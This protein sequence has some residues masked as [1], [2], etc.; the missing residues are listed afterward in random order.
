MSL[1]SVLQRMAP[2]RCLVVAL[3]A[4]SISVLSV[5]SARADPPELDAFV[6]EV[7]SRSPALH[8]DRLRRESLRK[9][10]TAEG[11]WPDPFATVMVDQVPAMPGS[12]ATMIRYQ[13]QQMLP[14]PGKLGMM[15][16]A[17]EWRAKGAAATVEV[18][19]LELVAEAKRE[20]LMLLLNSRK[21]QINRASYDLL[22]SIARAAGARYA[23]GTGGH[24]ELVRAE[25]ERNS[26][27]VD[28]VALDG[29]RVS[30]VAMLN[31]LRNGRVDEPITDPEPFETP[32]RE[33]VVSSLID[34]AVRQRPEL[35]QMET[36]RRE[37]QVMADLARRERYP[38]LMVGAWY[39]QML[40]EP[41]SG[42]AMI[43]A[44]LP[45]VGVTRQNRQ[46]AA[47]DTRADSVAQDVEAMRAMIRFEVADAVRKVQTADRSLAFLRTIA[48]PRAKENIEVSLAA[49][50]TGGVDMISLL[51]ARRALQAAE[52]SIAEAEVERE[53]A[54]AELDRATGREPGAKSR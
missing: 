5:S 2:L 13:L 7:L 48:L 6:R 37:T 52:L 47:L 18:R 36:M 33:L 29:E 4:L 15:R 43:G 46:A 50:V 11:L 12:E 53:M 10:S 45:V 9:E 19:R 20:W 25:V 41:D 14:W 42:G 26:L 1:A 44:A 34:Q 8:G 30:I 16:S 40:G 32:G 54:W 3:M 38:D 31:A 39:N 35:R 21:R 51:D 27:D 17:A 49:Y 28:K 22:T 24:H 23:G